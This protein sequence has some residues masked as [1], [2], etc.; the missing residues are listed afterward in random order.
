M[1]PWAHGRI[2]LS[3]PRDPARG[4][5]VLVLHPYADDARVLTSGG[6]SRAPAERILWEAPGVAPELGDTWGNAGAVERARLAIAH[7]HERHGLEPGPV[8]VAGASM[9]A[10]TAL[11]LA[12]AHPG[13]IGCLLLV[14]PVV[15]PGALFDALGAEDRMRTTMAAAHG[16]RPAH[17]DVGRT[18]GIPQRWWSSAD[19]PVTPERT[20]RAA[21]REAGATW[22]SLGPVGHFPYS[23]D[24]LEAL[25]FYRATMPCGPP[26]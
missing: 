7:G 5:L 12:R 10:L 18:R 26:K 4:P 21:A 17:P 2:A 19:D 15:A 1:E 9:G 22:S 11:Q 25:A 14:L 13:L 24:P 23:V 3:T 20:V 6:F 16:G 8:V